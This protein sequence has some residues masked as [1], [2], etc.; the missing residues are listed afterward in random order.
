M[1][2]Q[3]PLKVYRGFR[4]D[5]GTAVEVTTRNSERVRSSEH[6]LFNTLSDYAKKK[7]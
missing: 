4:A 1:R 7:R 6:S 2:K 3:R 5:G